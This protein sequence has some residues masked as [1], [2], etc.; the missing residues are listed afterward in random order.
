[1]NAF[2]RHIYIY[3]ILIILIIFTPLISIQYDTIAEFNLGS[4]AEYT[5]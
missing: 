3:D 2:Q 4:K 1:M 5:A